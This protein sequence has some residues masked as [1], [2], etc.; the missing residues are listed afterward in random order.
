MYA[1]FVL[2][3]DATAI[4]QPKSYDVTQAAVKAGK[5]SLREVGLPIQGMTAYVP[6]GRVLLMQGRTNTL[7][8]AVQ[9]FIQA[10]GATEIR[11]VGAG[12]AE[13]GGEG[14]SFV[15]LY[16]RFWRWAVNE[17]TLIA[18]ASSATVT[19]RGTDPWMPMP[20]P[21]L[22]GRVDLTRFYELLN[23]AHHAFDSRQ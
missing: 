9:Y 23:E 14:T 17:L 20:T 8:A 18:L 12:G 7:D 10:T 6:D 11:A 21:T 13:P 19:N 1:K 15:A 5:T 2:I 3:E 4:A 22:N 16:Q